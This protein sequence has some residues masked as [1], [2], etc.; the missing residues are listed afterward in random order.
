MY[1]PGLGKYLSNVWNGEVSVVR[2]EKADLK[3]FGEVE[4][5]CTSV[6]GSRVNMGSSLRFFHISIVTD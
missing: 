2:E 4:H 6:A 3:F 5:D 1:L